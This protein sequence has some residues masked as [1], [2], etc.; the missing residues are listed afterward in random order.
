MGRAGERRQDLNDP[1]LAYRAAVIREPLEDI[2]AVLGTRI[3]DDRFFVCG[4]IAGGDEDGRGVG[5][6]IHRGGVHRK[7]LLRFTDMTVRRF[8][9]LLPHGEHL[10]AALAEAQGLTAADLMHGARVILQLQAEQQLFK[11]IPGEGIEADAEAEFARRDRGHG[12]VHIRFRCGDVGKI[13]VPVDLSAG[14]PGLIRIGIP[15]EYRFVLALFLIE[16]LQIPHG[17]VVVPRAG[18]VFIA[19]AP[20]LGR[21][22]IELGG[23][24]LRRAENIQRDLGAVGYGGHGVGIEKAKSA[25]HGALVAHH[26]EQAA[27]RAGA[28]LIAAGLMLMVLFQYV[29]DRVAEKFLRHARG[30]EIDHRVREI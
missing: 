5:I 15:L 12:G 4:Q 1:G 2:V 23:G 16:H 30:G 7:G 21:Q 19:A 29:K 25:H 13:A 11:L 6:R 14:E 3:I 24:D 17:I 22:Q 9:G 20:A 8:I 27:R 10:H 18:G 28:A 26:A